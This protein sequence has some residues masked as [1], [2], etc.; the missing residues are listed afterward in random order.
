MCVSF[1]SVCIFFSLF[2][3]RIHQQT[4]REPGNN[5]VIFFLKGLLV[6]MAENFIRRINHYLAYLLT[7]TSAL[8]TVGWFIEW[9]ILST[10]WTT[11]SRNI[12]VILSDVTHFGFVMAQNK[13]NYPSYSCPND[14]S[15]HVA[16]EFCGYTFLWTILNLQNKT[17]QKAITYSLEKEIEEST[18]GIGE[19]LWFSMV[20]VLV[21]WVKEL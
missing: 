14:R 3:R 12:S 19:G 11:R 21:L 16:L 20:V 18:Q 17:L 4:Y 1:W 8:S 13:N 6:R 2:P 9:I 15:C 7:K 5:N 10:L